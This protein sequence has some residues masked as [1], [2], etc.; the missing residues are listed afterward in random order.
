MLLIIGWLVV[1]GSI[2]GGFTFSGGHVASLFVV[3]EYLIIVG[4]AAGYTVA[5]S[6]LPVLKMMVGKILGTFKGSRFNKNFYLD[7]VKGLYELLMVAREQGVVGIE[8]HVLHPEESVIF[9]KYPRFLADHHAI[10]FMQDGLRPVIDGKVKPDQLKGMLESDLDRMHAQHAQPITVLSKVG[11]AMP[12]IGIVAAVLGIIITM[13]SIA[14]DKAEIGEHVAHALVGTFLGILISYG[15][16]QPLTTNIEFQNED[17]LSFFEVI[18]NM[19][20][21]YASGASPMDAAESGRRA[22][23]ADRQISNEELE[24]TLKELITKK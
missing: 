12:G 6:P 24:K 22:I 14:G 11:D 16:V 23:P 17:E 13:A 15:F 2:L 9:K 8:E 20:T 3:G 19:I 5:A 18:M 1:S 21:A 4:V 10:T 7:A